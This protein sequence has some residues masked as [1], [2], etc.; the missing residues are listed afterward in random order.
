MT[1][2]VIYKRRYLLRKITK[3]IPVAL[4]LGILWDYIAIE[5]GWWSYGKEFLLGPSILGIPIEDFLFFIVVPAGAVA[6]YDLIN[7]PAKN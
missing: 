6:V 1:V 3:A 4:V 2:S 7:N 5:R